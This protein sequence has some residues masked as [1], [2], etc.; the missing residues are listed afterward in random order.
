MLM[1]FPFHSSDAADWE[2]KPC[3]FGTWRSFGKPG[4][5]AY[6]NNR[7]SKQN[8]RCEVEWYLEL[9]RRLQVKWKKE[10]DVLEAQTPLTVRL[11]AGGGRSIQDVGIAAINGP[12]KPQKRK[13]K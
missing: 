2:V 11:V 13:G 6:L 8:L 12:N 10:M 1:T 7:G 5:T 4:S 3:Q 9:E